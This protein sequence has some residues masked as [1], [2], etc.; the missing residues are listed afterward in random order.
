MYDDDEYIRRRFGDQ[1]RSPWFA[2]SDYKEILV[3]CHRKLHGER[4]F[5]AVV[6][7]ALILLLMQCMGGDEETAQTTTRSR[8]TTSQTFSAVVQPKVN[9]VQ[10]SRTGEEHF[11]D[12]RPNQESDRICAK[13]VRGHWWVKFI[14]GATAS[15]DFQMKHFRDWSDTTPHITVRFWFANGMW[16]QSPPRDGPGWKASQ[17]I[18]LS[19]DE[20]HAMRTSVQLT[21][22]GN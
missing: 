2:Q 10:F 6:L 22:I 7:L 18:S 11:F 17:C 8:T 14:E 15:T 5:G 12:V 19:H 3:G 16:Q 13:S 4:V 1:K 20:P 9:S 21:S